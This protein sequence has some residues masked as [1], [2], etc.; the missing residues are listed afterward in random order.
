MKMIQK[1]LKSLLCAGLGLILCLLL[2]G[3]IGMTAQ[4]AESKTYNGFTYEK[5]KDG[6]TITG[7]TGGETAVV[8][9]AKIKGTQVTKIGKNAFLYS[10]MTSVKMP[11]GLK[12]I[13]FQAFAGCN[14]L[15]SVTVPDSVT[16]I[17]TGAFATCYNLSSIKLSKNLKS[18]G[19]W[20]FYICDSLESIVIPRKVT[21][22]EHALFQNCDNLSSV[23]LPDGL[24]SIGADAFSGCSSLTDITLPDSLTS[25]G[26]GAFGGCSSLT[27]LILPDGLT[28]IG[29]WAFSDCSSLT[30]ITL[31][32]GIKSIGSCTFSRTGITSI[33]I[34]RGVTDIGERAFANC[35]KLK[36]ITIPNSVKNMFVS[37]SMGENYTFLNGSPNATIICNKNSAAYKYAK[38][39]KIPVRSIRKP[40]K[41]GTT[42]TVSSK[43]IK[44]KVTSSAM[45]NPTVTVTKITD[46]KAAKLS[47]PATVKVGGVTYKVTAIADKAFKGNKKLTIVTIGRNVKKIGKE[48]FAGCQNL[49]KI[50]V[51]AGRLTGI[52][53]NAFKGINKNATITMNGVAQAK[54]VLKTRLK[55]SYVGHVKTWKIK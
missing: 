47:I 49:K 46:K 54:T 29:G 4:A 48:A 40:A 9:P 27:S 28:S 17:G 22:L 3:G 14:G 38:E 21:K 18:M 37:S 39:Y 31:P 34:P 45:L 41:K 20:V 7:Y 10:N 32:S 2:C 11:E 6:I 53:K 13:G 33:T 30:D 1:K 43:K 44:V 19:E 15:T 25:I 8:I 35:D 16:S 26:G 51:T 52:G 5:G 55:K 50:S 42:F 12:T 23:T 24:T 36:Y